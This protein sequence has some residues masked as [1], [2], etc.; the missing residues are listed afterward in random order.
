[1]TV[2]I[3]S[4]NPAKVQAVKDAFRKSFG[5]TTFT[6]VPVP[7]TPSG[8]NAQ[9]MGDEETQQGARNRAMNAIDLYHEKDI[10]YSVGLEGGCEIREDG[11]YHCF[12]WMAV[13]SVKEE[14]WGLART[15]SFVL[16][17]AIAK[18]M[19]QGMELGEADDLVFRKKDSKK[20]DGSVGILTHGVINRSEY[21]Q[22]A[23]V[24]AL[25]PFVNPTLY[26]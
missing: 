1:M 26:D 4:G 22:H 21:Y 15:A 9:P 20:S 3:G 14:K 2:L 6:F 5:S 10:V 8:V 12:A 18:L 17:K 24:L 7:S 19:S 25:I 16:P 11:S 13:Y 23:L